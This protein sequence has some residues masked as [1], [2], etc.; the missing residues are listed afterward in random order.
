[1]EVLFISGG[2]AG[3]LLV[4][5]RFTISRW[6][7]GRFEESSW[8]GLFGFFEVKTILRTSVSISLKSLGTCGAD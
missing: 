4:C 3:L 6:S 8:F 5:L 1:M 2:L 7:R